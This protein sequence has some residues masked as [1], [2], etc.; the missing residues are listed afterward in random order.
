MPND[1]IDRM[2]TINGWRQTNW[3]TSSLLNIMY[4]RIKDVLLD[5]KYLV[6]IS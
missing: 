4:S 5:V 1:S 6:A 3:N 2:I